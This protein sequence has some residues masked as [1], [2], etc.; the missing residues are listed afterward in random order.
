MKR[1]QGTKIL[2]GI[3][4]R[5]RAES[6]QNEDHQPLGCSKMSFSPPSRDFKSYDLTSPLSML[7]PACI[8]LLLTKVQQC[9]HASMFDVLRRVVATL[10]LSASSGGE[11]TNGGL[12]RHTSSGQF[13]SRKGA[14][15]MIRTTF[16]HTI[17]HNGHCFCSETQK[18]LDRQTD[19]GRKNRSPR[20]SI[21]SRRQKTTRD[22]LRN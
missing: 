9:F 20:Q 2:E 13:P 10:E 4:K 7:S 3:V 12:P 6:D 8:S 22:E 1:E 16:R 17:A 21:P 5:N 11:A 15:A 19:V 18:L 14:K